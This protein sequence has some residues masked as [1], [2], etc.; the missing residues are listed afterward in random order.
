MRLIYLTAKQYP[1]GTADHH[2]ISNL[3]DSFYAELGE[4]FT[5]VAV[6]TK[7]NA[8]PNLPVISLNFPHIIKRTLAFFIWIPWYWFINQKQ[9]T[10]DHVIFFSNDLNL[11]TILI[12]WKKVLHLPYIIISDW[13]LLTHTWTD[14]FVASHS[15]VLLTTSMRLQ[16]TL[17]TLA[18]SAVVQTVYGGISLE[19][20]L[21]DVDKNKLRSF[22]N[23]PRDKMLVGYVGHFKTMGMEKG[24]ATMIEALPNL[25]SKIIMV[26]V[27]GTQ[28]EIEHYKAFARKKGVS[29][30]CLWLSLQPFEHVVQYEQALDMLVIPYPDESHFRDYGFPMKV[31]EYMASGTPIIYS[32][33]PLA[34]EV[35]SDCAF[36]ISPDNPRA[37][38][39]M[40]D[41]LNTHESS[42]REKAI[43]ARNKVERYTWTEKA[44]QILQ[45]VT[46]L[47]K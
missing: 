12:L 6:N 42:A 16:Q 14:K 18:P 22:L 36:G 29:E 21:A 9:F 34:E 43:I 24:V 13:H 30:R 32:T 15:D 27:G 7:K 31:Y 19:R 1:G 17:K 40:I 44:R 35:L 11:L 33:L 45:L 47:Q 5:F 25:N 10:N 3:A 4:K 37:L 2:Y 26:F 38:S 28:Q 41:F 23:L 46:T 20:Y 39:D 8:L